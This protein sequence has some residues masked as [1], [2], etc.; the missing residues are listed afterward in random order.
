MVWYS[1]P[2]CR[3][4]FARAERLWF[5]A[6]CTGCGV[7][8]KVFE[9]TLPPRRTSPTRAQA[10]MSHPTQAFQREP[11]RKPHPGDSG[12]D[13]WGR[14]LPKPWYKGPGPPNPSGD[15]WKVRRRHWRACLMCGQ[16]FAGRANQ[17]FCSARCRERHWYWEHVAFCRAYQQRRYVA[18]RA[19]SL[20]VSPHP[21]P[22][23]LDAK[24]IDP[25]HTGTW[26]SSGL[27]W[28]PSPSPP[29]PPPKI[30]VLGHLRGAP[31]DVRP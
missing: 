28:G 27:A 14:F 22:R 26:R 23:S 18:S 29:T 15:R 11:P 5:D 8:F 31:G 17:R 7:K 4:T 25:T 21:P 6:R 13:R 1:C 2:S 9:N 3:L 20:E 12:R 10:A 19:R 24:V 30:I 16:A